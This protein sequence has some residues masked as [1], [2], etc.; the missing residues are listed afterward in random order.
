MTGWGGLWGGAWGALDPE[1]PNV[2]APTVV[3][4]YPPPGTVIQATT[5]IAFS[6]RDEV[7]LAYVAVTVYFPGQP[8]EIA[9]DGNNLTAGYAADSVLSPQPPTRIDMLLS[10]VGG[11]RDSPKLRVQAV[12][13]G[14]LEYEVVLEWLLGP[15]VVAPTTATPV[16]TQPGRL[17]LVRPMQRNR[18]NDFTTAAPSAARRERVVQLLATKARSPNSAGELRWDPDFGSRLHELRHRSGAGVLELAELYVRQAFA[19]WEPTLAVGGVSMLP[20]DPAFPTRRV[21]RITF[22]DLVQG[23]EDAVEV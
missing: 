23:D 9:F 21:F 19:R 1:A 8:A 10:R 15:A 11:W 16:R 3:E 6:V 13:T 14:G 22:R 5:P 7:A 20:K 2:T 17:A 4:V 12:D 18:A